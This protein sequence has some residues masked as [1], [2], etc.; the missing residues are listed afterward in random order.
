MDTGSCFSVN[1]GQHQESI[2]TDGMRLQGHQAT[3]NFVE[4]QSLF[5]DLFLQGLDLSI[6]EHN[7]LLLALV[8]QA[9]ET[10]QQNVPWL[11]REW[12]V[13]R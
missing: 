2:S 6:L 3:L 9:A 11:E 13:R 10:G 5:S 1:G 8:H 4:Q 12:P 7:H